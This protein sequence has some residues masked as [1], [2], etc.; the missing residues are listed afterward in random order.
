MRHRTEELFCFYLM[1]ASRASGRE[2]AIDSEV[3]EFMSARKAEFRRRLK[4]AMSK[5]PSY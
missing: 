2:V 3:R 5:Q 1:R 4:C